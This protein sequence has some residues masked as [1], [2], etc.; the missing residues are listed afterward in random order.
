MKAIGRMTNEGTPRGRSAEVRD[1]FSPEDANY[2]SSNRATPPCANTKA[3]P[4]VSGGH[5]D[6]T[7]GEHPVR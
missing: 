3:F 2:V 4:C 1:W 7:A 6:C 5:G